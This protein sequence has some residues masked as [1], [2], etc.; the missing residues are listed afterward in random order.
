MYNDIK[1]IYIYISCVYMIYIYMIYCIR[2]WHMYI[3]YWYDI[4]IYISIHIHWMAIPCVFPCVL[5]VCVGRPYHAGVGLEGGVST[6]TYRF[7]HTVF[8]LSGI[9]NVP[10]RFSWGDS[11][12]PFFWIRIAWCILRQPLLAR[13]YGKKRNSQKSMIQQ[14]KKWCPLC[15][16]KYFPTSFF[17]SKL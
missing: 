8:R 12:Y 3:W 7:R 14:F 17:L 4:Y 11:F 16:W 1:N 15:Y 6:H 5:L 2:I 9:I 10:L 13:I